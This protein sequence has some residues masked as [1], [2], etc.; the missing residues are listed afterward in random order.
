MMEDAIDDWL[1]RQIQWL[2]RDDVIA[3]GIRWVQNVLWP[4]GI[5]FLRL[6]TQSRMD[7]YQPDQRSFEITSQRS[8]V[9]KPGSFEQQL[10]AARRASDIKKMI[11]NGAPTTLVS[12]IGHKQYRR[13][14]K[15]IYF[16]LQS[17]VCLKQ[18][19]Y[20]I[21]ELV[22]ITVFPELRDLV[23]EIHKKMRAQAVYKL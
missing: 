13:C 11:F 19:A 21:L 7:D 17:T 18:L 20:G 1:L 2:R 8:Q 10:E 12:L 4:D 22:I 23:V 9:S 6:R 3:Q 15:D 5:F 14:A 16:F